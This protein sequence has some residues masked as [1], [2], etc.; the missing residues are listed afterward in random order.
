MMISTPNKP[1]PLISNGS[2]HQGSDARLPR[3]FPIYTGNGSYNLPPRDAKYHQLAS[4]HNKPTP[5]T[6]SVNIR[7]LKSDR[8]TN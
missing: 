1:A 8:L 6:G 3:L 4:H 7:V 5:P 2:R